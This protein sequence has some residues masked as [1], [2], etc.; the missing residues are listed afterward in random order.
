MKTDRLPVAIAIAAQK[1]A[2][3]SLEKVKPMPALAKTTSTIALFHQRNG[4]QKGPNKQHLHKPEASSST[5]GQDSTHMWRPVLELAGKPERLPSLLSSS[6]PS[7]T[8]GT[9]CV[10]SSPAQSKPIEH[11]GRSSASSKESK[12][13]SLPARALDTSTPWSIDFSHESLDCIESDDESSVCS[14]ASVPPS[15]ITVEKLRQW[16]ADLRIDTALEEKLTRQLAEFRVSPVKQRA[17]RSGKQS[18][19]RQRKQIAVSSPQ[20]VVLPSSDDQT[21]ASSPVSQARDLPATTPAD[22]QPVKD[23]GPSKLSLLL[24]STVTS[25]AP[26]QTRMPDVS[27]GPGETMA[28]GTAAPSARVSKRKPK[29]SV[30]AFKAASKKPLAAAREKH[31]LKPASTGVGSSKTL[32]PFKKQGVQ[33]TPALPVPGTS[34][35]GMTE[36]QSSEMFSVQG[37]S[38]PDPSVKVVPAP[39]REQGTAYAPV[40]ETP[41]EPHVSSAIEEQQPQPMAVTS[42]L[43]AA[44]A[45]LPELHPAAMEDQPQPIALAQ[46]LLS[47]PSSSGVEVE[48]TVQESSGQFSYQEP[49]Q[50]LHDAGAIAEPT[51]P[52]SSLQD[53]EAL[54]RPL[55]DLELADDMDFTYD[56]SATEVDYD[57]NV[58]MSDDGPDSGYASN[59]D[60]ASASPED[61]VPDCMDIDEDMGALGD[62]PELSQ[63]FSPEELRYMEL[64]QQHLEQQELFVL[65]QQF[66]RQLQQQQDQQNCEQQQQQPPPVAQPTTPN[67]APDSEPQQPP[68]DSS[69]ASHAAA[70]EAK[71][72]DRRA[73]I[74]KLEAI[75]E[76]GQEH[77]GNGRP[78]HQERIQEAMSK[79]HKTS[80]SDRDHDRR[81]ELER[82]R[83]RDR[84]DSGR[85]RR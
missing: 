67:A 40:Q 78:A 2:D 42:E 62:E 55:A 76:C 9:E 61:D 3:D 39:D 71:E 72:R 64:E 37:H 18:A 68:L 59:E 60:P 38:L 51:T 74:A 57:G 84:K 83:D 32:S 6:S 20:A 14:S 50:L 82:R 31:G 4:F 17:A 21:A 36:Q 54:L 47:G 26:P 81:R 58:T 33:T 73:R 24:A 43:E 13:L 53:L 10:S 27:D 25:S 41:L 79:R 46:P 48:M 5:A 11:T 19:R 77:R 49:Q 75:A 16:L 63:W 29:P 85:V 1:D 52:P 45:T 65:Q 30:A 66:D 34:P 22:Q 69:Q 15:C 70:R 28:P 80:G 44:P 7:S 23:N 12:K 8:P 56:G 35:G